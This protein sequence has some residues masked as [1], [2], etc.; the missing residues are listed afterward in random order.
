MD[1]IYRDAFS[2]LLTWKENPKHKPVLLR[3]ARQVGKTTLIR[4]FAGK[5]AEID[6]LS[7]E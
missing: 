3:G 1:V 5:N 2:K 7:S 6:P 4:Q